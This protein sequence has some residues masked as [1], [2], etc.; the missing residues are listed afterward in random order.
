M[1]ALAVGLVEQ[2]RHTVGTDSVRPPVVGEARRVHPA[3]AEHGG[4]IL[5]GAVVPHGVAAARPVDQIRVAGGVYEHLG[6]DLGQAA[7]GINYHPIKNIPLLDDAENIGMIEDARPCA[8]HQLLG[9]FFI[10]LGIVGD[11]I[12]LAVELRGRHAAPG[13]HGLEKL[14]CK[15]EDG[16]AG[17]VGFRRVTAQ[18]CTADRAG[19]TGHCR[20]PQ[21]TQPLHQK[22]GAPLPGGHGGRRN[23]GRPTAAD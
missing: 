8:Q 1:P 21:K 6:A 2:L 15:A 12:G 9:H 14:L 17:A 22:D 5:D 3:Q 19:T 20:A 7:L 10:D 4:G 16:L 18:K 23:A 13:A 11:E